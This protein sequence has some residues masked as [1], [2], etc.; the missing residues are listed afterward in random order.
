MTITTSKQGVWTL[1]EVYKKTLSGYFTYVANDPGETQLFVVGNYA[2]DQTPGAE[3]YPPYRRSSPVQIPGTTWRGGKN[4]SPSSN[5]WWG[6]KSDN[7]LWFWGQG[8][9]GKFGVNASCQYAPSPSQLPGTAWC[10]VHGSLNT[11]AIK[12]DGTLWGWGINSEGL[13]GTNTYGTFPNTISVSSPIQV[14]GTQW[15]AICHGR[16]VAGAL[17]T[18]NTLWMWGANRNGELGQNF[19][20]CANSSPIQVPGTQWCAIAPSSTTL[21]L[22]TDNTLWAWGRN[23]VGDDTGIPRSSPVQIPGTSWCCIS[24]GAYT[25]MA[26]KT[27][28]SLW[29][30]GQNRGGAFGN[31]TAGDATLKSSPIQL[32]GSWSKVCTEGDHAVGIKTDG[33]LWVWGKDDS[34]QLG[35]NT[36]NICYSSPVQIPGTCWGFAG[37]GYDTSSTFMKCF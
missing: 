16:S 26:L 36:V 37:V 35:L 12:T 4:F 31:N 20:T 11:N 24:V 18:N 33:T 34:G 28:N 19:L 8:A 17:K 27:D 29:V 30:W 32:P 3:N 2:P 25:K 23:P 14:P 10:A 21:A 5:A 13:T 1:D 15:C 9:S 7:T 22:K 6:I